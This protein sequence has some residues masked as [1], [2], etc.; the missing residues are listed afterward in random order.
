MRTFTQSEEDLSYP[1]AILIFVIAGLACAPLWAGYDAGDGSTEHP[2]EIA[3]PNQLIY[4]SQHPEDWNKNFLLTAD[5][6]MNLAEPNT[7]TTALIAP[8]TDIFYAWYSGTP[9][10]GYFNGN[11][12]VIANLHIVQNTSYLDH[13]GF[14]G[15]IDGGFVENLGIE[16][17]LI[18]L[19]NYSRTAGALAARNR[20]TIRNCYSSGNIENGYAT[21]G[22]LVGGNSGLIIDSWS[23]C[24]VSGQFN[25]EYIG[26]LAGSNG[27]RIERCCASG[28][29]W[30]D[31]SALMVGGLV[32]NNPSGE[33]IYCCSTGSVIGLSN[34]YDIGG[35]VGRN[36]GDIYYCYSATS[37]NVS[38]TIENVG[39][40]AGHNYFGNIEGCYTS[41]SIIGVGS[42][43]SYVGGFTALNYYS[44]IRNCF[45]NT[46]NCY[47][48]H[49]VSS[50]TGGNIVNLEGI[51]S[52]QMQQEETFTNPPANWDFVGETVN[53]PGDDW[54]MPESSGFPVLWWQLDPWPTLPIFSGGD[55]S[56]SDPFLIADSN[57]LNCIGHN[58]RLMDKHFRLIENLDCDGID[59]FMIGS[60]VLPFIGV[61]DGQKYAV[62]NVS[63]HFSGEFSYIGMFT[64]LGEYGNIQNLGLENMIIE[65]G[66][67]KNAGALVGVL[68]INALI[69]N[70]YAKGTL[71]VGDYSE[72]I[73]G[74]AGDNKG[75]ISYSFTDM[76]VTAGNNVT[77]L[78]GF[79]GRNFSPGTISK[80]YSLGTISW[81]S[82]GRYVGGFAGRN[83]ASPEENLSFCFAATALNSGPSPVSIGG[84]LG[85]NAEYPY[86]DLGISYWDIEVSGYTDGVG[87]Q[88]PDPDGIVG[89]TTE[90]MAH[91][92]NFDG[93]DFEDVWD[94]CEGTSYPRL[95]WQILAGDFVCPYGV[96]PE[97]LI[98]L[99]EHWLQTKCRPSTYNADIN[100]DDIVDIYDF[101]ILATSWLLN[102]CGQ[103]SGADLDGN[104][105]VDV[106]DNIILMNRWL[107]RFNGD[108]GMCDLNDD[109][110]VNILDYSI[111][112]ANWLK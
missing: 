80:C 63:L 76:T 79:V 85:N 61:F 106:L 37:I 87:N 71:T 25:C 59:Y 15:E 3:E 67:T 78:G 21:L 5:I 30:G 58:S 44:D 19:G 107:D 47:V 45:W 65:T 68:D 16:N 66:T 27:G 81:G 12:H 75:E 94:I 33:I 35:L 55:G 24:L 42:N 101:S 82:V 112:S 72:N 57:D 103:C 69:D 111:L 17:I 64:R 54:A 20:G 28:I 50:N 77:S 4:M 22:G 9:F 18:T 32:G 43:P 88:E 13:V 95:V 99:S 48:V 14:F 6:N 11:N 53:G 1:R 83:I 34:S 70:C 105:Q 10:T 91:Q 39:G 52:E 7:F 8:D 109:G 60:E 56:E 62:S 97:D 102:E 89:L 26:G 46:T 36:N 93:W 104:E 86:F 108:C 38:S 41:S 110:I 92:E 40:L 96:G 31:E 49:G 98:H 90:Q 100:G 29:V 2:F 74:I 51:S 23:S 73:G 84:F